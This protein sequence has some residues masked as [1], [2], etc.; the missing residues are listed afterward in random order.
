MKKQRT[1]VAVMGIWA[2]VSCCSAV[3][4]PRPEV[5]EIESN[6][7]VQ[8]RLLEVASSFAMVVTNYQDWV[9]VE[10]EVA[11]LMK[12]AG[13]DRKNILREMLY[14]MTYERERW[15]P[16][17]GPHLMEVLAYFNFTR[18]EVVAVV[19][20]YLESTDD[21]LVEVSVQI[22]YNTVNGTWEKYH[23]SMLS[24]IEKVKAKDGNPLQSSPEITLNAGTNAPVHDLYDLYLSLDV[25]LA[26]LPMGCVHSGLSPVE[27]TPRPLVISTERKIK[28]FCEGFYEKDFSSLLDYAAI[29]EVFVLSF[30]DKDENKIGICGW[31]LMSPESADALF[32]KASAK[33]ASRAERMKFW[34]YKDLV[35]MLFRG[36]GVT[37]ACIGKFQEHVER[38]LNKAK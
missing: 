27:K 3:D 17:H 15:P 33:H 31:R 24:G 35:V 25:P 4:L 22:L 34:L 18:Q 19:K 12:A 20:P 36:D 30:K 1:L 6:L 16:G 8:N 7:I 9:Q 21:R 29:R 14:L 5:K 11:A 23:R 37:D 32:K 13:Q 38:T 26:E 2:S 10:K 28:N